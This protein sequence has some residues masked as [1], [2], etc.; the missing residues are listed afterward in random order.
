MYGR[1]ATDQ[2]FWYKEKGKMTNRH[3]WNDIQTGR[4]DVAAGLEEMTR[5]WRRAAA[6]TAL[7]DNDDLYEGREG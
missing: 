1:C 3:T 2:R 6:A 5:Q 7:V 4:W